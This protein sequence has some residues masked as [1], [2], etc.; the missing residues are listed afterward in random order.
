[1]NDIGVP[2]ERHWRF[3]LLRMAL[4]LAFFVALGVGV[5]LALVRPGIQTAILTIPFV[6]VLAGIAL[7]FTLR[8]RRWTRPDPE[9]NRIMRDE[10]V[11][12]NYERA[13]RIALRAIWMAQ[14]PLMFLVAYIPPD[15]TVG[16]SVVGMAMLTM[17]TGGTAFLGSYLVYSREPSDG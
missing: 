9:D 11:R 5:I 6:F 15:P 7:R 4:G 2:S 12:R 1:M 16:G 8:G 17:A 10:W 3:H 14:A 13:R